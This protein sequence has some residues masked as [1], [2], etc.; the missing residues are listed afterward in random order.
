[1]SYTGI[2]IEIQSL[3]HDVGVQCT[4]QIPDVMGSSTRNTEVSQ[5]E[6]ELSDLD[7]IHETTSTFSSPQESSG[8]V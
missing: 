8:E 4:L 6:S 7:S 3:C 2:Q 1:M 5:S